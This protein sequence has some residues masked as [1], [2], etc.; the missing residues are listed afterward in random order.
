MASPAAAA[1]L[2]AS[3]VPG[4]VPAHLDVIDEKKLQGFWEECEE[5][6][7]NKEKAEAGPSKDS[8][9]GGKNSKLLDGLE[10]AVSTNT[11]DSRG[12]LAQRLMREMKGNKE[13]QEKWKAAKGN[14]EKAAFRLEWAK[15]KLQEVRVV[16]QRFRSF[17][18]V[19]ETLGEYMPLMK[20]IGEEGGDKTAV[21]AGLKYAIKCARMGGRWTLWN[22]MTERTE[23]LYLRKIYKTVFTNAWN[24]FDN[25]IG[26]ATETLPQAA[27]GIQQDQFSIH[28]FLK[29]LFGDVCRQPFPEAFH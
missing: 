12:P 16:C 21:T 19:D 29:D 14:E 2:A 26:G 4:T 23:F 15:M 10:G 27:Q 1:S 13:M 18:T 11:V 6:L 5:E 24:Q 22:P 8:E 9:T 3:A 20:I 17:Q 28:I 25:Y 7:K